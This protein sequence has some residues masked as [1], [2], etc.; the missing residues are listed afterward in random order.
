MS[1]GKVVIQI[2]ADPSD[3]EKAIGSLGAST[4]KSLAT[5][6]KGS[7]IGNLFAQAFSKAAGVIANSMDA[8]ISRVDIMKNFPRVMESL[9]YSADDAA[10]S[11]QKMSDH[12]TGLPT[13]LDS[14]TSS[15]QKIVPTVKDV[16]KA[17]DIMLAFNDALL[18]GGSSTQ[19]QEAA[20]EQ[21]S[22]ALAKGK[23]E[24]EDWRSI[25]TAMPGQLDQVAQ[26]MLGQGKSATDLYEALKHGDVTMS[27]FCDALV[28]LDKEGGANFASFAEQAKLGTEG[29]ATGWSNF[30]N[31]VIKGVASV[32]NAIGSE[33]IVG[34]IGDASKTVTQFFKAVS[35]GV[36]AAMPSVVQIGTALSKM[37]PQI[38]AALAGF[39]GFKSAGGIV[40]DVAGRLGQL[41]KGAGLAAKASAVLGR[42]ISPVG[43][44]ITVA[45]VA[46]GLFA[47][48]VTDYVTNTE[49]A[50]KATT[51]LSDAAANTAALGSYSGAVQAIGYSA[52]ASAPSIS[53]LNA[54]I[55]SSVDTMNKTTESAQQQVD[56]LSTAQSIIQQYAGQTDLSST[57]QG[58]LQ[59]ALQEVNNQLG[60]SLT[61]ADAASN[62]YKDQDGNVRSLTESVNGLVEAKK[63]EIELSAMESNYTEALKKKTEAEDA[64]AAK[65]V[66]RGQ[67]I[68]D[69]KNALIQASNYSMSQQEAEAQ[70]TEIVDAKLA[71]YKGTVDN[72]T[73]AVDDIAAAM[74]DAS[75]ATSDSADA[76]DRWGNTVTDKF[77]TAAAILKQNLGANGLGQL[78]DDLR[79]LG[80]STEDLGNLTAD[81][82]QELALAYDGTSA[83]IVGKLAEWG[84][85]M[86][87]AK[88]KTAEGIAAIRDS[89]NGMGVGDAFSQAGIDID[90]FSQKLAEAGVSAEQLN[91][92]GSEN[93]SALAQSCNGNTDQMIAAITAFNGTPMLDKNS[94]VYIYDTELTDAQ[95]NVYTWNGTALVD[96]N[97]TAIVQDTSLTDAQGHNYVWNGTALVSKQASANVNGNASNGQA[98]GQVDNTNSSVD[99][100]HDKSVNASVSGNAADGSAA[101]SI[102]DTVSA[103]GSLVGKSI[104]NTVTNVVHSITGNAKGGIRPHADGGF[105]P[106][107]H[108]HGAIATKAVPL[109]IVGEDGAEAIVPLT[110]ERYARPFAQ[111][112]AREVDGMSTLDLDID[113]ARAELAMQ[114]ATQYA[115]LGQAFMQG[116]QEVTLRLDGVN[117]RL[118]RIE[119]KMDREVSV[120]I[121]SREFGRLVRG[122]R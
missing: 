45:A 103:I 42:S 4:Q 56:T 104:T 11:I 99:R 95:G 16:G 6:I 27:D 15:V 13:R 80:A 20:L 37:G 31:S 78:K 63:R 55:A 12:L 98:K 51:G 118:D 117:Q 14:M 64:Y 71:E 77:G 44:A 111:M 7:F 10:S 47:G 39:A 73:S 84:V 66:S 70:A 30:L 38:V 54:S 62:S 68:Q 81:Q 9:G 2:T 90:A 96:K 112:I 89:L 24:L 116:I 94:G 114:S 72:T 109:D 17:T 3:Y 23:P 19:V 76:Y 26:S 29:I 5:A 102:W 35:S 106:R 60:L 87:D 88:A 67:D 18:A 8:A 25:Q 59:W 93:L 43:I 79:E 83:S 49:N 32:I 61:A 58:R 69:T 86:D 65:V 100:M 1:D 48:A 105:V 40:S 33:N 122:V 28:R 34:V 110:N 50:K 52:K 108:A 41:E 22:Q 53:E 46:V 101:R 97:G 115:L 21:F 91:S 82:M 74:G 92:I 107:F 85:G 75:K 57:A 121:D 36:S 113:Q 119:R 120:R